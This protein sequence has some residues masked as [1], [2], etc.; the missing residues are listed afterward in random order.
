MHEQK[1]TK[2]KRRSV[3]NTSKSQTKQEK[4]AK[5]FDDIRKAIE[6][7]DKATDRLAFVQRHFRD[8]SEMLTKAITELRNAEYDLNFER[9]L[10]EGHVSSL[11]K[12]TERYLNSIEKLAEKEEKARKQSTENLKKDALRLAN[13]EKQNDTLRFQNEL[14]E[15][16]V[17]L[18]EMLEAVNIR[19]IRLTKELED[20]DRKKTL[21][22]LNNLK[23][24][25]G[26]GLFNGIITSY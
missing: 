12:L 26:E 4:F 6:R 1:K 19:H 10:A 25:L 11:N 9:K 16:Q 22:I 23:A 5:N 21:E 7:V 14:G 13:L 2:G 3:S 20:A 8:D 17:Q 24:T 15:D 18:S